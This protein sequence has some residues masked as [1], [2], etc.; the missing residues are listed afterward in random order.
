VLQVYEAEAKKRPAGVN[1][2]A[3]IF[4]VELVAGVE[5]EIARLFAPVDLA[6]A[7]VIG[8]IQRFSLEKRASASPTASRASSPA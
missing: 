7:V 8:L 3:V 6:F 2:R 4:I 1:R 5:V